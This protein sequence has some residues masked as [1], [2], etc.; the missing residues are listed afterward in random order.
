MSRKLMESIPGQGEKTQGWEMEIT[1]W[2]LFCKLIIE[3]S[4][5]D[6]SCG[7]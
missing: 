5:F 7:I 6:Y 4:I 1:D 2:S 3:S